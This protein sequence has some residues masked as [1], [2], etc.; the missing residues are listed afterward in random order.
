MGKQLSFAVALNLLTTG[1]TK[2]ANKANG[3]LRSIQLQV[4]NLSMAFAAGAIGIG[5]FTGQIMTSVKGMSKATQTLKN[6]TGDSYEYS[7]ALQ[8]VNGQSKRY[9]QELIS[10][11]GNYARFYAAARGSNM[12]LKDTQ[13]V[14]DALT[15]S[16]TYFNLS[17]DETSG[18]MLAVTQMMS[19]GKITAEELRGQLGERL[20]GAIQIMARA[21]SVTTGELDA[22]MKKGQL[23]A[24]EV[25]P[26]FGQQLKIETMN[27]NPN[28]I[29]GSINKLRNTITEL[30]AT[31]RM[32]KLMSGIINTI[33]NAFEVVANNIKNIMAGV[34]GTVAYLGANSFKKMY[35]GFDT[36]ATTIYAQ[37]KGL[38]DAAK[39]I[40]II[41]GT[42]GADLP[43]KSQIDEYKKALN[44]SNNPSFGNAGKIKEVDQLEKKY[45]A[46]NRTVKGNIETYAQLGQSLETT[47]A[48][49]GR[50]VKIVGSNLVNAFKKLSAS[51]K[52]FLISNWITIAIASLT[53][54]I[55]KIVQTV[56]E[57]KRIKDIPFES[58]R[59]INTVEK[60]YSAGGAGYKQEEAKLQVIKEMYLDINTSIAK[61]KQLLQMLGIPSE[62]V[63]GYT[64]KQLESEDLINSAITERLKLIKEEAVLRAKAQEYTRILARKEEVQTEIAKTSSGMSKGELVFSMVSPNNPLSDK[65]GDIKAYQK[66]IDALD[67]ILKTRG[68]E[69]E[70]AFK[71]L[72]ARNLKET[73]STG[74]GDD[75]N[76]LQKYAK[77]RKELDNQLKNGAISQQEYYEG[78][79]KLTDS[80]LKQIGVLDKVEGKYKELFYSLLEENLGLQDIDIEIK[81][82]E[83]KV[84]TDKFQKKLQEDLSKDLYVPVRPEA[85]DKTFDYKK[86]ASQQLEEQLQIAQKLK[87]ELKK[88]VESGLSNYKAELEVVITGEKDL[89]KALKLAE[90]QED[91]KKIQDELNDATFSSIKD[92]AMSAERLVEAFK[93]VNDTLADSDASGFEKVMSIVNALIQTVDS[94]SSVAK[95]IQTLT[96]WT[97]KLTLA[98]EAEN[99]IIGTKGVTE[100]AAIASV[101]AAKA[102]AAA[103]EAPII[104][105]QIALAKTATAA[106][107][108]QMAAETAAAYASIPFAGV[109]LAAGQIAALEAMIIAA[110]IPK[111]ANGGIVSG[112]T[113]GMMGEYAG[114]STNP[115]VIAPLNKLKSLLK[116]DEGGTGNSEVTFKIKGDELVGVLSN[117]NKKKSK[118]R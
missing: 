36:K 96:E 24:S 51:L 81:D 57:A 20:P 52:S 116:L 1:F 79:V 48:S 29:E 103:T 60:S 2:G 107:S 26:L 104:I 62:T 53:F 114:A 117:H 86:T 43:L 17:A 108:G 109:A 99:T 72:E 58:Q 14:F 6:V 39:K 28:S 111:F 115:E 64:S 56:N 87:E 89:S 67:G 65:L 25:L 44:D 55:S 40:Q 16:S 22:M 46:L 31:E 38:Q 73:L 101:T 82:P 15:Q 110:G 63:K 33:T 45:K 11:T 94:I 47:T 13:N 102:T 61:R 113:I 69:F 42:D 18:V 88:A 50:L 9:N 70:D 76:T 3:A 5:N 74:S 93:N 4:R 32:Q 19:K 68:A 21:L 7:K 80:Y 112:A 49:G 41:T 106:F 8:F 23:V 98:K 97:A 91:I 54:F 118:V 10:L 92:V 66:E 83:I 75:L 78:V 59:N 37:Y 85:R 95:G 34:W 90:V 12:N 84:D 71:K 105:G 27:F 77:E 35:N 100:V 30:F